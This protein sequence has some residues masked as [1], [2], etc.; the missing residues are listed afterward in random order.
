MVGDKDKGGETDKNGVQGILIEFSS[1]WARFKCW[2]V[3]V[4][5]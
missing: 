4:V 5:K 3:F 2:N 1:F